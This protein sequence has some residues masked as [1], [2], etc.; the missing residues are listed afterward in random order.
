MKIRILFKDPDAVSEAV[1]DA[2][3]NLKRPDGVDED[4]WEDIVQSRKEGL[5]LKPWIEYMEYCTV[6]IDT[7][8]KTAIVVPRKP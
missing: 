3:K 8:A 4:E 7:E 6:E 2:F 5:S 1:D